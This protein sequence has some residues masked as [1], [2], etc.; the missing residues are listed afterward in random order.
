VEVTHPF[1]TKR[2]DTDPVFQYQ[3]VK[4]FQDHVLKPLQYIMSSM[5]KTF[6]IY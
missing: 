1:R 5:I 3:Y 6:K 2:K 4:E